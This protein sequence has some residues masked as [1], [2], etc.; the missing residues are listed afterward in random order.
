MPGCDLV[1]GLTGVGVATLGGATAAV[2]DLVSL[3][4]TIIVLFIIN[5]FDWKMN[6]FRN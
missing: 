1:A 5:I 4:L 2:S 6:W 3:T